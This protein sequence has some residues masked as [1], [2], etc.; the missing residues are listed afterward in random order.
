MFLIVY[1][2]LEAIKRAVAF[3]AS[4]PQRTIWDASPYMNSLDASILVYI[5]VD[6]RVYVSEMFILVYSQLEAIKRAVAFTA[7]AP[8]GT[9]WDAS[10]IEQLSQACDEWAQVPLEPGHRRIIK[11]TCS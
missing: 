7:S 10:P 5:C 9:I 4:A 11:P 1:S 6:T 8:K 3:T 2:Q